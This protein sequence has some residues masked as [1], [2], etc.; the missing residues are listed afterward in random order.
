M[1]TLSTPT[2]LMVILSLS[3]YGADA[4]KKVSEPFYTD[5]IAAVVNGEVVT[6]FDIIRETAA[7]EVK[8]QE[9]SKDSKKAREQIVALRRTAGERLVER[10]LL[11]AEFE[12]LGGVVPEDIVQERINRIVQQ[13]SMGNRQQ[14]E[15]ELRKS[16]M[17]MSEFEKKVAKDL[18][19]ELL[20]Q[21]KVR[22][23]VRISP[24]AVATYY[25]EH[26]DEFG[27]PGRVRLRV[28][29]LKKDGKYAGRL[30]AVEKEIRKKADSG[31]DF[32]NLARQY[33]E[34]S[35]AAKGGDLGWVVESQLRKDFREAIE[36]LEPGQL[37]K[38]LITTSGRFILRLDSVEKARVSP[39]T[40]ELERKIENK[41][42][43]QAE[44]RRYKEYIAQL[45]KKYYVRKY[46]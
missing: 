26:A 34:G 30:D 29:F 17:T 36:P 5:S 23:A 3:L 11:S 15:Q 19:V 25:R 2:V 7:L 32:V 39:L 16:D 13:K 28:I 44:D 18:A 6:V 40:P 22:R 45:S 14:F 42:R 8:I 9:R 38:T 35:G 46:F 10:E 43:R 37:A 33:S 21:E 27:V 41:L 4:D 1:R 24:A 20:V 31:A 12:K